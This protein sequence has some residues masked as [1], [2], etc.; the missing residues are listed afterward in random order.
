MFPLRQLPTSNLKGTSELFRYI[1]ACIPG[2]S[3]AGSFAIWKPFAAT[4]SG[5]TTVFSQD[6]AVDAVIQGRILCGF[7]QNTR[8]RCPLSGHVSLVRSKR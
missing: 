1:G 5:S 6:T 2:N 8:F 4:Q 7:R 3:G